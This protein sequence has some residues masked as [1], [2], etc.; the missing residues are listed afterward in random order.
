M[1]AAIARHPELRRLSFTGSV[2]T[3]LRIAAGAAESG[4]IKTVT[5]ELGGKNPMIVFPDA[6]LEQAAAAAVRGMNFTRV[7]GQSCGSTS[8]LFLHDAIHDEV[9]ERVREIA[10]AIVV[11]DPLDPAIEMGALIS[12]DS[13]DRCLG[14]IARAQDEG[15][16]LVLGGRS[17]AVSG[18][19][20]GA[21]L[22]PT[23]LRGSHHD[24]DLAQNEIFGPVLSVHRWSDRDE[25]V[26][27]ANDVR[28]GLTG[29]IWTS[30]VSEAIRTAEELETGF[31][32][33]NDV[34]TRYPAVPFGGW[35]DS[36]SGLEHGIEEL[37]SFT[38]TKAVNLRFK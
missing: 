38:R 19:D 14:I 22:E 12:T 27:Q 11:G 36:G 15:A 26:R 2:P 8:R 18:L 4:V 17:A 30:D 28:Y 33:I 1:G 9:L 34:E 31:I 10:G 6:D 25:V 29:A 37:L 13:R 5:Y 32:W 7:Q 35:K 23:I 24:S 3:A 20:G 16:S 21:F